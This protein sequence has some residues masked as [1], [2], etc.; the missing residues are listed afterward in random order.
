MRTK[1]GGGAF[2]IPMLNNYHV[3]I[4]APKDILK[5][6]KAPADEISFNGVTE[7]VRIS[8][9][10]VSIFRERAQVVIRLG[11]IQEIHAT[12]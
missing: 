3:Y 12:Q 5:L 10:L 4:S 11:T 8:L 6:S 7:E 1:S 9:H 2:A